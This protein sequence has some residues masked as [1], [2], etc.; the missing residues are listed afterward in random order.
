ML[1]FV[2]RAIASKSASVSAQVVESQSQLPGINVLTNA[3]T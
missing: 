2:Q 3:K 1:R